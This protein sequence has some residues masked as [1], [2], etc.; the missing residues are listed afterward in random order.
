MVLPFVHRDTTKIIKRKVYYYAEI[1]DGGG[2]HS[3]YLL[4][5]GVDSRI[6][7]VRNPSHKKKVRKCADKPYV[8]PN[9][10]L[11]N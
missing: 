4:K 9:H 10:H 8:E 5:S 6:I 7:P 1:S 11:R 2:T 3:M